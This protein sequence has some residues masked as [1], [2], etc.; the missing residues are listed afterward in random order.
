ME[1]YYTDSE[2]TLYCGDAG[3]TLRA[4]PDHSVHCVVT[5]PPYFRLR[6]Y[7]HPDQIGLEETPQE[8][9]SRLMRVFDEVWRVLRPDGTVWVNLGDSYAQDS[10]W[11]GVPDKNLLGIPWRVAFGLQDA[12]W[13]V[14][15]DIV[16]AKPNAMPSSVTDRPTASHE[17]IFLLTKQQRYYYDAVAIAEPS[18]SDHGSG[19]GFKRSA[20]LVAGGRGNDQ[21]W[22]PQPT[23]NARDVWHI[24]VQGYPDAH[25]AVF[26]EELPRRCLL[27]GT[28]PQTCEQCGA[29][30]RRITEKAMNMDRP[31]AR[32][33]ID[34]FRQHGLTDEHLHAM[35]AVGFADA[36]KAV[37]TMRGADQNS[38]DTQ[39]LA[40]EAKAVLGGYFREFLGGGSVT[41]GWG[42]TCACANQG[43]GSSVVLDPFAG[44]GTTLTTA[45]L[46]G[47]RAIGIELN[48]AYCELALNRLRQ[49]VLPLFSPAINE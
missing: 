28:S 23:R 45:R 46:H 38:A 4:L 40:A 16:W 12:G 35:R 42:P 9:V 37:V 7:G 48:S 18:V 43:T 26:P 6:D 41:T 14:R 21:G 31:Q 32:R 30:W 20:R 44:S 49:N 8:Y 1:P 34:L 47:R 3:E 15:S 5:S 27:A 39:R 11:G 22:A 29:P 25:F 33:A 36:G 13:I 17:H 19:N 2:V 24:N 10:K